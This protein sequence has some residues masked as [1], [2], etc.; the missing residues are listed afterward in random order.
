[1]SAKATGIGTVK[2]GCRL[3]NAGLP[4]GYWAKEIDIFAQNGESG[5]EILY[6]V[7]AGWAD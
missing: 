7:M 4:D 1:M 6:G 5:K 3:K 2:I